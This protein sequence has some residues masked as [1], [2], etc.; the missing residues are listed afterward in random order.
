MAGSDPLFEDWGAHWRRLVEARE[1]QASAFR[2]PAY[3]DKRARSFNA[4][5]SGRKDGFLEVLEPWLAPDRTLIDVGAGAGRYA[6]PLA[7][8]L[9]WV[10]AV[11]PSQGMRDLIPPR[12]NM[13]VIASDWERAEAAPADL[14]ICC[15]VLYGVA[16][17]C[18]FI[19][20]LE[21]NARRRVFIQLRYGQLRTPADPLW[22]QLLGAPRARQPAFGDLWNLLEK[23][24]IHADVAVLRYQTFQ[25]WA[26]EQE[27][28]DEFRPQLA[29]AWDDSKARRW[30]AENLVREA[31]GTLVYG[32]AESFAG[33]AHW[34]PRQ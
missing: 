6:A 24:G 18:R 2:D 4:A 13:T 30:M 23:M 20:K 21:A 1:A 33:V 11:E 27:F 22:E 25:V 28:L 10:T 12:D 16:D 26:N 17:A 8:R 14:V 7:D 15:H 9:D 29:A 32:R 5:T 3:W 31:D 19:E 34:Q